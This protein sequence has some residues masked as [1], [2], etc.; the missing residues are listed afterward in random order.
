MLLLQERARD[1][2]IELRFETEIEPASIY[3]QKHDLVVA[4]DG[5]NSRTRSAFADVFEPEIETRAC[6]FVWLGTGTKLAFE[7]AIALANVLHLE[8]TLD[9]A[10]SRYQEE[11]R[12]EVLRLQSAARNSTSSRSVDGC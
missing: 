8:P 9:A 7:S 2:G 4:A 6:K 10:F 3:L 1:L 5:L 12:V 11:R